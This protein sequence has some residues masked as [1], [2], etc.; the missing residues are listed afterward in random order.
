MKIFSCFINMCEGS[1]GVR[2]RHEVWEPINIWTM[3]HKTF[4]NDS[5]ISNIRYFNFIGREK[6]L[7]RRPCM[8]HLVGW[9]KVSNK[10]WDIQN[11]VGGTMFKINATFTLTFS[12]WVVSQQNIWNFWIIKRGEGLICLNHVPRRS[13]INDKGRISY[14]ACNQ[15][16]NTLLVFETRY[17]FVLLCAIKKGYFFL[18]QDLIQHINMLLQLRDLRIKSLPTVCALASLTFTFLLLKVILLGFWGLLMRLGRVSF[19]I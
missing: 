7:L 18:L 3:I 14:R 11:I 12:F 17:S 15:V 13:R 4:S 6:N 5:S 16:M 1:R 19:F 8:S 9:K 2:E 10:T